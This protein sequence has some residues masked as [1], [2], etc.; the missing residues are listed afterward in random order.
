MNA[1]LPF[2]TPSHV[3]IV[4]DTGER[5]V[6]TVAVHARLGVDALIRLHADDFALLDR[7]GRTFVHFNLERTTNRVGLR[8]ALVPI[9]RAGSRDAG[10]AEVL[11][12]VDVRRLRTGTCIEVLQRVPL[13]SVTEA[14]LS[15]SLPGIR[16]VGQL[17]A[18]LVQR[19]G[20]MFPGLDE[21]QLAAHGCSITRLNLDEQLA[22]PAVAARG[23]S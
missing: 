13:D 1:E 12:V 20:A 7:V 8:Y 14:Q 21:A 2:S 4:D 18:A 9:W 6:A 23:Q 17:R 15:L 19:Y 3:G 11:P 5:V 10:G 22:G 16:S